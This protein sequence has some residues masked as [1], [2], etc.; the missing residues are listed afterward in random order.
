MP[1][2]QSL[3][4]TL[5]RRDILAQLVLKWDSE[6]HAA[7]QR[8]ILIKADCSH[9]HRDVLHTLPRARAVG[10]KLRQLN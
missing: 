10:L 5:E 2:F 3:T 1:L 6:V 7:V 8:T 4:Y 9:K